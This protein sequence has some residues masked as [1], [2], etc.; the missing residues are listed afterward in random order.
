MKEERQEVGTEVC[1]PAAVRSQ[2]GIVCWDLVQCRTAQLWLLWAP[3]CDVQQKPFSAGAGM[4]SGCS[5]P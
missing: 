1:P 4:G 3:M 2:R 5:L